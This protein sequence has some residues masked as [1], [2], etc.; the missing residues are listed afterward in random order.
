MV[1]GLAYQAKAV[2]ALQQLGKDQMRFGACKWRTKAVMSTKAEGQVASIFTG[3]VE[4]VRFYELCAIAVGSRDV[5]DR[6]PTFGHR[7]LTYCDVARRDSTGELNWWVIAEDLLHS[8]GD[9]VGLICSSR[10]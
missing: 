6:K 5:D 9:A 7:R 1:A 4:R 3:H 2:T 8:T 10:A